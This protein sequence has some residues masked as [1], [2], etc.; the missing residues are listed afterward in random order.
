MSQQKN[1]TLMKSLTLALAIFGA[2][3]SS[4]Q[5]A[6]VLKGVDPAH[7][8]QKRNHRPDVSAELQRLS[9]EVS[10]AVLDN[11]SAFVVEAG[12]SKAAR[13]AELT[14]LKTGAL[15][16]LSQHGDDAR[17][18]AALTRAIDD[19][20]VGVAAVAAERLGQTKR[21]D[22]LAV[23]AAVVVDGARDEGV[24]AGAAAGLGRHRSEAAWHVLAQLV[25]DKAQPDVVRVAALHATASLTSRW[26]WQARDDAATGDRLRQDAVVVVA[27]VDGSAAV[28]AAKAE[29]LRL[30]Q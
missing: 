18:R 30:L 1:H 12:Q 10:L 6:V 5:P 15:A 13:A 25:G 8:L 21:A 29:A 2:S 3:A 16:A 11:P 9:P 27:A 28:V 23:L 7:Y 19:R 26:A 4:A 22:A 17:A 20:D 14:A 24:R